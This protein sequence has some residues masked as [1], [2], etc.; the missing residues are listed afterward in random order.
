MSSGRFK[1]DSRISFRASHGEKE[2]AAMFAR[3]EG[4]SV[5]KF[6]IEL[7][8]LYGRHKLVGITGGSGKLRELEKAEAKDE[9]SRILT[10]ATEEAENARKS[11]ELAGREEGFRLREAWEKEE[12]EG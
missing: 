10:R 8:R 9:A 5:G 4:V 12:K 2:L 6:F 11:G 1:L 7:L 3:Q